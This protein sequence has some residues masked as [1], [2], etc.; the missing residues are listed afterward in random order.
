MLKPGATAFQSL[1][2]PNCLPTCWFYPCA[3]RG[4]ERC[5]DRAIRGARFLRSTGIASSCSKCYL[6]LLMNACEAMRDNAPNDRTLSWQPLMAAARDLVCHRLRLRA[7][8][9]RR[10]TIVRAFITTKA[11][12]LGLGLSICRSIVS[13]TTGWISARN[14]ADRGAT[15][16]WCCPWRRSNRRPRQARQSHAQGSRRRKG[17]LFTRVGELKRGT[18]DSL[19]RARSPRDAGAATK[20]STRQRRTSAPRSDVVDLERE[21]RFGRASIRRAGENFAALRIAQLDDE[22]GL[23]DGG[24]V[25]AAAAE[26]RRV[27]VGR[28]VRHDIDDG[29]DEQQHVRSGRR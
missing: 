12:G 2:F 11:D 15:I 20:P 9:G 24:Q 10:G 6:N 3:A 13:C 28:N 1:D 19:R 27:D 23:A 21:G 7:G 4:A 18:W 26:S 14:N 22:R 8:S 5:S 16:D 29:A 17:P 25:D